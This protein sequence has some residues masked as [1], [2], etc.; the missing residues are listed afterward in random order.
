MLL[1]VT[2]GDIYQMEI[3]HGFGVV[4]EETIGL[5]ATRVHVPLVRVVL[6]TR[7]IRVLVKKLQISGAPC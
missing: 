7:A 1:M 2:F 5:G 3:R 4:L 6:V